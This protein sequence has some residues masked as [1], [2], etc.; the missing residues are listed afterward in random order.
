MMLISKTAPPKNL[1]LQAVI[2]DWAGTLVDYGSCAPLAA[3]AEV[4]QL[5]GVPITDAEGRQPMGKEKREHL[6]ELLGMQEI[7]ARWRET[8]GAAP[9]PRELDRL[10]SDF[11]ARQ[12]SCVTSHAG[13]VPGASACV[14]ECRRRG[15]KIGSSSGYTQEVLN[16]LV[17]LSQEQ[18]CN[19]DAVV[20]AGEVP[21]G[22]PAPW[23]IWENARRLQVYP[24]A[25]LVT[26]DDTAVGIQAGLNA[27]TWTVGVVA[28]GNLIGLPLDEFQRLAE[29]R[30]QQLL[31]MGYEAMQ[32]AGAHYVIDTVAD[33]PA[34]LDHIEQRLAQGGRP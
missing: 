28:S 33:L 11:V 21:A 32:A 29:D 26:I 25:T 1:R 10:Y 16:R 15:L 9:G 8:H 7:R 4:F 12:P 22:R 2:F 31:A 17:A 14:N 30:R 13:L 34:V 18:G 20:S 3:F 23:M 5:H 6:S 27:G 24:P 19:L